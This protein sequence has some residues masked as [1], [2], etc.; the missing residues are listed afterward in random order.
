MLTRLL[1]IQRN[2]YFQLIFSLKVRREFSVELQTGFT[3]NF[4]SLP[5][6]HVQRPH[7][8]KWRAV[9]SAWTISVGLSAFV[10]VYA[11]ENYV[12]FNI[13]WQTFDSSIIYPIY[14]RCTHIFCRNH[15]HFS[16]AVDM[17]AIKQTKLAHKCAKICCSIYDKISCCTSR[18]TSR[19]WE[20]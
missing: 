15:A 1:D 13:P 9:F 7:K 11:A 12:Q 16:S 18:A 17:K 10:S 2:K 4:H 6:R 14:E 3:D 20:N 19:M 8:T 5:H